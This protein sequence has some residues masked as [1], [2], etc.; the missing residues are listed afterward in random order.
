MPYVP[1]EEYACARL[2]NGRDDDG[3]VNPATAY[4]QSR[5]RSHS[6][7]ASLRSNSG[8]FSTC[9]ISGQDLLGC[10]GIGADR[11]R[12]TGQNGITL[13]ERVAGDDWPLAARQPCPII[14]SGLFVPLVPLSYERYQATGVQTKSRDD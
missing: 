2:S 12:Q 4:V 14:P 11:E 1:G 5:N 9:K 13:D 7:P 10:F 6:Q 8:D 3:I